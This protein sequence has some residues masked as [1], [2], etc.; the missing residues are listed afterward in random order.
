[1]ETT[2]AA[3]VRDERG[4]GPAHRLRAAGRVPAILY[5]HGMDPVGTSWST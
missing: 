3:E 1:M 2:L 5:G 4:K